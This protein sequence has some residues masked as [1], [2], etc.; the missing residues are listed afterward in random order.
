ML[1]SGRFPRGNCTAAHSVK[2]AH[3]W[4]CPAGELQDCT[5]T[6]ACE[7]AKRTFDGSKSGGKYLMRTCARGK[8]KVHVRHPGCCSVPRQEAVHG[9]RAHL[10]LPHGDGLL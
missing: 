10:A 4:T 9:S 1:L 7:T 5:I 6:R 8:G 3:I 2:C